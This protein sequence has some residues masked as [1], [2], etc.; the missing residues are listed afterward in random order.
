[1]IVAEEMCRS[2]VRVHCCV[3]TQARFTTEQKTPSG[4]CLNEESPTE[5]ISE[6]GHCD[7]AIGNAAIADNK[8]EI[9]SSYD[10]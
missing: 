7:V 6:V 3:V 8:F 10:H 4:T 5:H 9:S 2:V 1:M